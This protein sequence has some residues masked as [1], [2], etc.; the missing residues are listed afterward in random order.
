MSLPPPP[1]LSAPPPGL[2][3]NPSIAHPEQQQTN[4]EAGPSSS[5]LT[6]EQLEAKKRKWLS[7]Q[8]KRWNE[9]RKAGGGGGVDGGKQ[10]ECDP[11]STRKGRKGGRARLLPVD[12]ASLIGFLP[13][14]RGRL[15]RLD[16]DAGAH[17]YPYPRRA[18]LL[19]SAYLCL[20]LV[21]IRSP[22]HRSPSTSSL[23]ALRRRHRSMQTCLL[24]I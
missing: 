12:L 14:I 4:G 6:A 7:L 15:A 13:L 23:A 16:G 17:K 9:K 10:G 5:S 1:G 19:L 21:F 20:V 2:P 8:T 3:S 18:D 24:N 22:F 11:I